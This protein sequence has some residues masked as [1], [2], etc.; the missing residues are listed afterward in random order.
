MNF[1][2]L[3]W[4]YKKDNNKNIQKPSEWRKE[5]GKGPNV[6]SHWIYSY[7][8]NPDRL[9]I[10]MQQVARIVGLEKGAE[11][12]RITD[13]LKTLLRPP[14]PSPRPV[15]HHGHLDCY[16]LGKNT[17]GLFSW[18]IK[19]EKLWAQKLQ[20]NRETEVKIKKLNEILYKNC[21]TMSSLVHPAPRNHRSRCIALR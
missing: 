7:Q 5:N 6:G 16:C 4:L 1:F 20:A 17:Q 8:K 21:W 19:S 10:E 13:H 9:Q 12:K 15:H 3:L 18:E 2:S 14:S 11:S